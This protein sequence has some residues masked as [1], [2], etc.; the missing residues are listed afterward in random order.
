MSSLVYPALPGIMFNSVRAPEFNTGLQRALS[1]KESRIAYQAFPC[2]T[3]TLD[4][5]LLRDYVNPSDFKALFGVYM[6]VMGRWDSLLYSDPVFNSVSLMQ[7]ATTDG[8]TTVFQ[9]TATYQNVGGPGAP[10]LIQN[11]NGTP[12][13]FVNRFGFPEQILAVSKTNQFL[14]SQAFDNAS[15]TKANVTI[16]PNTTL[17]PDITT[18]MDSVVESTAT[19]VG[20][21]VQQTL[22]VPS[23]VGT[24]TCS[25]YVKPST[26][27]WAF[28]NL[29]E[30]TAGSAANC[31]FNITT[32]VLGTA[33]IVG[34]NWSNV[35]GT[36]TAV[37]DD[38]GVFKITITG[39][40]TNAAT[41]ITA[42]IFSSTGDTISAYIGTVSTVAIILWGA[43]FEAGSVASFYLATTT[44]AVT[45][46]DYTLGVT[47]IITLS[48]ALAAGGGGGWGLY[49]NGNF[50][51]RVRFDD[52]SMDFSQFM[53]QFWET[54]KVKL[55]QVKL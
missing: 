13:Y 8:V 40:K 31:W 37:P 48:A 51:Y 41:S 11:F 43:Q 6:A 32:G 46:T 20:H 53:N 54:K 24:F 14:Q 50:Y 17:A 10:E 38:S 18:T 47:G 12:T 4:Y 33:Q 9:T 29:V 52:D 49:W 23:A 3:W 55:K 19:N 21:A 16:T 7:F 36:I 2:M 39:T 35:S 15:W 26:R 27:G 22:T 45:N 44:A 25:V 28:I 42:S 5:E 1:T 30:N 34:A